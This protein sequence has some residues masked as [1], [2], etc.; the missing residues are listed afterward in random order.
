MVL[1]RCQTFILTVC[2]SQNHVSVAQSHVSLLVSVCDSREERGGG[3]PM[4]CLIIS[5]MLL[6]NLPFSLVRP[7]K[8]ACQREGGQYATCPLTHCLRIL[9]CTF[10]DISQKLKEST[11]GIQSYS[12]CLNV[13]KI[14]FAIHAVCNLTFYISAIICLLQCQTYPEF[15]SCP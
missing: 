10:L 14:F 4:N 12:C 8:R 13:V 5:P 11:S 1:M 2:L 3:C 15:N 6:C 9:V 7:R